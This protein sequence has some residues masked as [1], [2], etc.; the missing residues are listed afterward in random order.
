MPA[1]CR[2]ER[3]GNAPENGRD[4]TT[5]HGC[6]QGSG[7]CCSHHDFEQVKLDAVGGRLLLPQVMCLAT[8]EDRARIL[9]VLLNVEGED[10]W[11]FWAREIPRFAGDKATED[12]SSLHRAA[13][14]GAFRSMR[15]LLAAG[16]DEMARDPFGFRASAGIG[17]AMP[18]SAK[19]PSKR[20]ATVARELKRAPAFRAR[21]WTWPATVG[22]DEDG[23]GGDRASGDGRRSR[24]C[25]A[26]SDQESTA[27]CESFPDDTWHNMVRRLFR[28]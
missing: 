8:F 4:F 27:G 11:Q 18:P 3:P 10:R 25:G 15:L 14:H 12:L 2:G 28:R 16:A 7:G 19:D 6:T 20:C 21:S 24:S 22:C 26:R 5:V 13:S 1:V 17:V 9:H 23:A